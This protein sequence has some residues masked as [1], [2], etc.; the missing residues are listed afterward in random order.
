MIQK[1]KFREITEENLAAFL[2]EPS[3][4]QVQHENK[5]ITDKDKL[6]AMAVQR[7]RSE[8]RCN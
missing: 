2:A 3:D 8:Q 6:W 5:P 1:W 4:S 7:A